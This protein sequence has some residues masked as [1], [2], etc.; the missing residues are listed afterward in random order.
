MRTPKVMELID[1]HTGKMRCKVCGAVHYANIKPGSG[2]RYYRGSWQCV[3]SCKL[4][5]HEE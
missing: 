3:N 1:P 2:G 5:T 4:P